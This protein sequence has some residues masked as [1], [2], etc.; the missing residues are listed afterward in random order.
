M[1]R[2][3]TT[4]ERF[5]AKCSRNGD[6]L[7]VAGHRE[8]NGYVR[9]KVNYKTVSAH[10]Y[11]YSSFVGEIPE[12]MLV[13]HTCDNP[14]CVNPEHLFLGTQQD[15]M[16]DKVAKGRQSQGETHHKS[17]L[18]KQQVLAIRR[19]NRSQRAIAHEYGIDQAAV[20]RIKNRK[21][22]KSVC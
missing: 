16:N 18:T 20:Q 1:G 14:P 10:R 15:N 21:V 11:S 17:K 19:D 5:L 13:L 22:W 3:K 6:C 12:G 9:I 4:P 2:P 7:E 8:T